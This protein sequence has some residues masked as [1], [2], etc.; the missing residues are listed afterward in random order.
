MPQASSSTEHTVTTVLPHPI[1][2]DKSR[3]SCFFRQGRLLA[4]QHEQG[5]VRAR[6][7]RDLLHSRIV[8]GSRPHGWFAAPTEAKLLSMLQPRE[9]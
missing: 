7:M 6:R 4:K 3:I 2:Q 5:K 1:F 8:G 9:N